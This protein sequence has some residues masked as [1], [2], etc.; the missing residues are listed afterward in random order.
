MSE[1][2]YRGGKINE[3]GFLNNFESQ[4]FTPAQCLLELVANSLDAMCQGKSKFIH[5]QY[6]DKTV[7][8]IDSAG[9]MD[10]EELDNMYDAYRGNHAAEQSCGRSGLGG[11]IAQKLLSQSTQTTVFSHKKGGR[12]WKIIAPWHTNKYHGKTEFWE[13]TADE[14]K[15][16]N[17]ER[18]NNGMVADGEEPTGTTQIFPYNDELYDVIRMNFTKG[19]HDQESDTESTSKSGKNKKG[20]V[21][22]EQHSNQ[23]L[24]PH[25]RIDVVFGRVKD[26]TISASMPCLKGGY[27]TLDFHDYFGKAQKEYYGGIDIDPI[28]QYRKAKQSRYV[29]E[30][31]NGR[32]WEHAISGRGISMELTQ[33][34]AKSLEDWIYVDRF[35][36]K[37]GL[38]MYP[39]FDPKSLT[40]ANAYHPYSSQ[41][42]GNNDK[43]HKYVKL[44]RNNQEIGLIKPPSEVKLQ[45][46]RADAMQNF[47]INFVQQ[48]LS[49]CPVSSQ[50]NFQDISIGIQLNKNQFNGENLPRNLT[51]LLNSIKKK[52]CKSLRAFLGIKKQSKDASNSVQETASQGEAHAEET[53]SVVDSGEE[54]SVKSMSPPVELSPE[55]NNEDLLDM[56]QLVLNDKIDSTQNAIPATINL[57]EAEHISSAEP[58]SGEDQNLSEVLVPDHR[59]ILPIDVVAHRKNGYFGHEAISI[60]NQFRDRFE[61]DSIYRDSRIVEI[62]NKIR[63]ISNGV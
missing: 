42:V 30:D 61:P 21:M 12:F 39:G 44:V 62:L 52:K 55:T 43:Y 60:L 35:Q 49:Y 54:N 13:M 7:A 16:F 34:S 56:K 11:K 63:A 40:G 37:T 23:S 2:F 51:R 18:Y 59:P 26:C 36:S 25:E 28:L 6:K 24:A 31:E 48:E 47:D 10:F 20:K 53:P 22:M 4:G 33:V 50:N 57:S 1:P 8:M 27:D 14:I 5:F 45:N 38:L 46:S 3:D 15:Q 32:K 19:S 9:G 41:F 17:E 29:W 58:P